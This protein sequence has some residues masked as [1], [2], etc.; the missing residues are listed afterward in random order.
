MNIYGLSTLVPLRD[1]RELKVA[2]ENLHESLRHV[3]QF[4]IW[5]KTNWNGLPKALR[6]ASVRQFK[7]EFIEAITKYLHAPIAA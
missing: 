3:Q 1:A 5:V 6:F 2:V 7:R 4:R